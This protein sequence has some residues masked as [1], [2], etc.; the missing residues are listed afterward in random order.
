MSKPENQRK[1]RFN[2]NLDEIPAV[3]RL[4]R[5]LGTILLAGRGGGGSFHLGAAI[6]IGPH[7]TGGPEI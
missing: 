3:E 4:Y 2:P 7:F 1:R 5:F 6:Y